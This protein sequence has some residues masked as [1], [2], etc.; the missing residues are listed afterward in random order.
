LPYLHPATP[1]SGASGTPVAKN[2]KIEER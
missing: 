1:K 2:A